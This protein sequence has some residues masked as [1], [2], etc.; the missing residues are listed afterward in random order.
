[1]LDVC[2]NNPAFTV[3]SLTASLNRVPYIPGYIGTLGL[4]RPE[5]LSTTTTFIE[6]RGTRLALVPELPRGSPATPDV[7]DRR[8]AVPMRVP[9]FPTRAA[10]YADS[11]QNVRAFGTEDQLQG[12]QEIVDEREASMGRRLDLTLEYLRLGA[13]KG[14]VITAV[15]RVTGAAEL[16]YDL[17]NLFGVQPQP[18]IE[19]PIIGAGAAAQDEAAWAGQLTGL[20]NNLGRAMADEVSG[21]AF[22]SI[23][24]VCGS[25]FFD[26]FSMHPERRAA[27]IALDSRP[28]VDAILGT[29]ISFRDVTIVEYRGKVGNVEF[30]EPDMGY[31]FPRGA[32]D[33][34]VEA[35]APADYL[36]TVNTVALPRYSKME[37][38]DFDKGVELEAQ[39]NVLPL[40]TTPR[41][42]F[43]ARAVP[44]VPL[45]LATAGKK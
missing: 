32:P 34:F 8:G 16:Q 20:C 7:D 15:N 6:V 3:M 9:H 14:T 2:S 1:M 40:C 10:I 26:A 25:V 29:R 21:G 45:A 22:Q 37:V 30:V 18:L 12:V 38:M 41:A 28:I 24:G 11:V 13:V 17:F 5:R 4:F 27:F 33:M 44:Y 35:Y 36:E 23:F 39:M 42:L 19:W 31:F 43:R